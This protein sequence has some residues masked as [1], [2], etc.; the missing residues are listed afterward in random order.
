MGLKYLRAAED[1]H[2][3][4]GIPAYDFAVEEADV[5]EDALSEAKFPSVST[6]LRMVRRARKSVSEIVQL[7]LKQEPGSG[8]KSEICIV[9]AG[10][11]ICQP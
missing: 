7:P 10:T 3:P 5:S 1:L 11:P 6:L 4:D 9:I 8:F 2:S